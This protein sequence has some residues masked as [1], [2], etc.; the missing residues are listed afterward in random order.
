[1][2]VKSHLRLLHGIIKT[3]KKHE[4]Q[5]MAAFPP[6]FESQ[7][8]LHCI[9]WVNIMN[10]IDLTD[11][12]LLVM[13][14][15]WD[16]ECLSV[17][18]IIDELY[19]RYGKSNKSSTIYTVL[20]RLKHKKYVDS[21]KDGTSYY[22]PLI[23]KKQYLEHFSQTITDFWGIQGRITLLVL[24]FQKLTPSK[25]QTEELLKLIDSHD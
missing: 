18:K 1:M 9:D 15:L 11:G 10:N 2:N 24:L 17:D 7:G 25:K 22:Y 3:I 23:P 21:Y 8:L 14:C 12:E 4:K 5:K 19:F 13:K 16:L 20:S 6:H